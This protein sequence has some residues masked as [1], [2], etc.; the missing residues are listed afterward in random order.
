MGRQ[1]KMAKNVGA[2]SNAP[3]NAAPDAVARLIDSVT[4]KQ[5][6]LNHVARVLHEEVGQV[7]TVV[8]LHLDVLRQDYGKANPELAGRTQEIQALLERAVSEVRD[9]CY[10][11]NPDVVQRSGLRYALDILIGRLRD[12]S[13]ATI[14]LLMDSHVH[15]P[16]PVAIALHQIAQQALANAVRHSGATLVEVV[17]QPAQAEV[18]LEIKDNG[19][20]FH[21]EQIQQAGSGLGLLWMQHAAQTAGLRLDIQTEPGQGTLVRTTYVAAQ[22]ATATAGT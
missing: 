10:R 15:V 3:V 14:R 7:L 1:T 2:P 5:A 9:L 8:G 4:E 6:E 20:G 21:R 11:I 13:Q 19:C 16:L 22:A 18:R 12:T 17:L